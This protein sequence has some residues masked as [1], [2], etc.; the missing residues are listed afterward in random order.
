M[1]KNI[2]YIVIGVGTFG[3]LMC[4]VFLGV[5]VVAKIVTDN[6]QPVTEQYIQQHLPIIPTFQNPQHLANVPVYPEPTQT[7]VYQ[8]S[9]VQGDCLTGTEYY[10][11]YTSLSNSIANLFFDTS[12]LWNMFNSNESL[13][14][15]STWDAEV[16]NDVQQSIVLA[17]QILALHPPRGWLVVSNPLDLAENSYIAG[18]NTELAGIQ[19][20]SPPLVNA[21]MPYF[22]AARN[23]M[24]E[25]KSAVY[26]TTNDNTCP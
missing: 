7:P 23:Y 25:V 2:L 5:G 20:H 1:N 13:F 3:F 15:D 10:D 6:N 8:A 21:D 17:D 22:A 9:V 16:E 24:N 14:F 18:F 12:N 11:Q 4:V 26:E 19:Q